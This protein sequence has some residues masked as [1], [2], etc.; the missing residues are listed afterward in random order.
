M[1]TRRELDPRIEAGI[2]GQFDGGNR[3]IIEVE[4]DD[5]DGV[6]YTTNMRSSD[7]IRDIYMGVFNLDKNQIIG[8]QVAWKG[9]PVISFRLKEKIKIDKLPAKFSYK[10]E[11]TLEDGTQLSQTIS[12]R[13]KGVRPPRQEDDGIR[14]V[15]FE[16]IGWK[17]AHE[18]I[19]AWASQFGQVLGKVREATDDDLDPDVMPD[20]NYVG[21]GN[22][23]V[24][25]KLRR[26]IPQFLPMYG[27]KVKVYYKDIP[28]VCTNCY[29]AG[30]IRRECT[31]ENKSWIEHVV[32][33]I[34][35]NE[36]IPEEMF[37]LWMKK[38]KD[39][40][41]ANL[42]QY[43]G[44]EESTDNGSTTSNVDLGDLNLESDDSEEL[45]T[46]VTEPQ[47]TVS[48]I[49]E[50]IETKT[51]STEA[52]KTKKINVQSESQP[53]G[54]QTK[55]PRGRPPGSTK[56]KEAHKNTKTKK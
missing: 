37:G 7:A 24:T 51:K 12:G 34:S 56:D 14:A 22:M 44:P 15:F 26:S 49:I 21:C 10:K 5:V 25:V 52:I 46:T 36:N 27:Y 39:Y 54:D 13:V 31:N 40:V 53:T 9:R 41:K 35:N 23:R 3:D 17:L 2:P 4:I 50:N 1:P 43:Q 11:K 8:I 32:E 18:Q 28:K 30:H 38:S 45:E 48:N 42:N 16:K 47:R 29:K 55:K 6:P 33:Y 19:E 20:D